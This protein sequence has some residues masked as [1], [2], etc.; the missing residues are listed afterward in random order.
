MRLK[1]TTALISSAAALVAVVGSGAVAVAA[2]PS[3]AR[4]AVTASAAEEH[5]VKYSDEDIVGLLVFA[6]GKAADEHPDLAAEIRAHRNEQTNQVTLAQIAE[7][8]KELM[9]TDPEFHDKITVAVQINDPFQAQAGM[10]RLNDDLKKFLTAHQVQGKSPNRADGWFWHD[11]NI[12][13]E[14]NA[15][16]AINGAVYANVAGA[17]EAVVALV[18]VPSAVSYGFDMSQP[19]SL[20][21]DGIVSA[22]TKG[23]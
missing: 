20:D 11:V 1:R 7:F 17:T 14:I 18:V 13:I 8:T 9:A 22:V 19:N 12:A 3:H 6:K 10:E 15:L 4:T 2:A 16:A 23:L 21:A 5:H